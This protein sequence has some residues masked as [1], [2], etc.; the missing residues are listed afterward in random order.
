MNIDPKLIDDFIRDNTA[1]L[2]EDIRAVVNIPSVEGAPLDGQP[3]GEGPYLA[4]QEALKIARRM[5]LDTHDCEGYM[6]Y[7]QIKGKSERQ[8]ASIAHLDVVPEGNGWTQNP[9]E[10]QVRDGYLIGRGVI[11]DKGP[12][13]VSLYA[14]KFF[15]ELGVEL[16]YTLRILLGAN[17]ETGMGDVDYY[18]KH[19][20]QPAFCMTPDGSF[21]VCYGEKGIFGGDL[22]SAEIMENIVEFRGGVAPNVIPDRA[23]ALVKGDISL[24]SDTENISLSQENGMIKISA[25]G[26]GGHA[27]HP[28]ATLNAIGLVVDYILDNK[29]GTA[30]ETEY[31]Q[32]LH[33]LHCDTTGASLGIDSSDGMFTPLTCIGGMIGSEGAVLIQNINIRYPTCITAEEIDDILS[34]KA[35]AAGADFIAERETVPFLVDPSSDVIKTLIKVYNDVM[36]KNEK[37]FTMGGGTYARHFTSAVSFGVEEE[38]AVYPDFVGKMHGADEGVPIELLLKTLEIYIIAIAKLQDLKL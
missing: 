2:I 7:A 18:L 6:G 26:I 27:A 12:A 19:Y 34:E 1:S 14:A 4:M 33:Q 3:F 35:Q 36:H 24:L 21:P 31:L 16:P 10:M 28:E 23:Y 30:K 5:G 17:E 11:D 15:K 9:F 8:I 13:I 22:V 32:L 38:G 29:L 20:E 25:K 37:P